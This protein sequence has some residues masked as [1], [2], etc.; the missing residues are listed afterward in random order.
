MN[1]IFRPSNQKLGWNGLGFKLSA[2]MAIIAAVPMVIIVSVVLISFSRS[3][4]SFTNVLETSRQ[5]M[6]DNVIGVRLQTE[7]KKAMADVESFMQD[8]VRT[9]VSFTHSPII[10]NSTAQA[11]LTAVSLGLTQL[12][13]S[14]LEEKMNDTRAMYLDN[15]ELMGYLVTF[16]KDNPEFSEVFFTDDHGFN[17]AYSNK[18]SDFLQA[19][20]DWWE[21]A[22]R[23]G[24]DIGQVEYDDSSGVYSVAVSAR[25]DGNNGL[26]LGVVKAVLNISALQNLSLNT[27]QNIDGGTVRL[28]T[29]DGYQIADTGSGNSSEVIM[30]DAGNLIQQ[31]WS[32]AMG[33]TGLPAGSFGYFSDKASLNGDN[34]VIGYALSTP[35]EGLGVSGLKDFNWVLMVEQPLNIALAPL[36]AFDQTLTELKDMRVSLFVSVLIIA[37]GSLLGALVIAFFFTRS[38][39]KPLNQT[40][41]VLQSVSEGNLSSRLDLDRKDEFGILSTSLN[42][43][44]ERLQG[45]VASEQE[46]RA[47]LE[48]SIQKYVEYTA[49]VMR[50]NL[51]ARVPL[52]TNGHGQDDALIVLGNSLN[53]MTDKLQVTIRQLG[54]SASNLNSAAAEILAAS[55]QQASGATEQSAA[56]SQTTTTV[57]EVKAITQQA[58][59]RMQEVASTSQRTV[60][61]ARL[62]QVAVQDT[63]NSMAQIKD[64]VEGIAE[65]ILALSEQTQQIGEIIATVNDIAAQSNM[66]A[67]N[68]SVEAARAGEHGKGFAVVAMEVRTLAEQSKQAT[69]QVKSILSE[70]QKATNVTVMATEE[71][72]KGVEHGVQL[73]AQA[74]EAI[75][76]LTV[77]I[78]ESAQAATQ[79]VAGG[80]QQ[81]TGIEQIAMAMQNINQATVQGLASTRQTEKSAQN[82]NELARQMAELVKLYKI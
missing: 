2:V 78:N 34:E 36:Q 81:Q 53:D 19:G 72:T 27:A 45:M 37:I 18:T 32:T 74:Q 66:L 3:V 73:A 5:N 8:H 24:I 50:G 60:E 52:S 70:I 14:E 1:K 67:L 77:A 56:I 63:I 25:I 23:D 64:R 82:L 15:A 75:Q 30:T 28:F 46:Q 17:V 71:G 12:S 59:L 42:R 39:T 9:M 20:E 68:A 47:Y 61:V 33:I 6:V 16:V 58:T 62:G 29:R 44:A 49:E 11:S 22:W 26:P 31:N 65:N 80:Q 38:I 55:T 41:D 51:S 76:Q 79:V 40:V 57:D 21:N 7:A 48:S 35:T 4:N 54:D 69:A 43:T 10:R 13:E